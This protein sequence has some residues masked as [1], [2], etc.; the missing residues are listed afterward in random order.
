MP[1]SVTGILTKRER[2]LDSGCP[3]AGHPGQSHLLPHR[4]RHDRH[5][6]V[7]QQQAG[8]QDQDRLDRDMLHERLDQPHFDATPTVE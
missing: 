7:S 2:G 3:R 5:E 6:H 4:P 1:V 8:H